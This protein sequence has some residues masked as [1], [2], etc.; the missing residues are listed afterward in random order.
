[1]SW[2]SKAASFSAG[3]AVALLALNPLSLPTPSLSVP[4]LDSLASIPYV[5]SIPYLDSFFPP[6]TDARANATFECKPQPYT[7]Q[8][9]STDPLVLY[10]HDFLSQAEIAALLAAGSDLF[11]PS[12][13]TKH[14]RSAPDTAR[15]SWSAGLPLGEPAVQCVLERAEGFMGTMMARGRDE[16]GAPQ[17]VRYAEGQKFDLHY[18]WYPS[19]QR[20]AGARKRR[21]NRPASFFAVLED[22]CEGGETWFPNVTAVEEQR[23][24]GRFPWRRH[25]EGGIAFSPVAGNAL[26]WVN[27]FA[28]GTGDER[29][30]HAGL[31]VTGGMK[32]AMNI[33]PK[34]YVGEDAWE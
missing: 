14:G 31:P 8:I 6:S 13:T 1:M 34:Q 25:E 10:V 15:T 21:W 9:V 2:T 12:L 30:R 22:G 32:T 27:L 29:T 19:F 26:F 3:I 28:N 5:S 33:W 23:G 17:L 18:D 16:M 7:T 24:E 11:K 20:A 4:H